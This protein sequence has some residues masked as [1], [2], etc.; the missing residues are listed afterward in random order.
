M[1]L[2]LASRARLALAMFSS[3]PNRLRLA[4][5]QTGLVNPSTLAT[6][7]NAL[8][9]HTAHDYMMQAIT[10]IP[11]PDM[12]L[13]RVGISR[14]QLA[15]LT[16]DDE[17][18]GAMET[19]RESACSTPWHLERPDTGGGNIEPDEDD[20]WIGKMI[21]RVWEPFAHA[22]WKS[23][24]FGYS[25]TEIIYSQEDDG[26][27]GLREA[28]EKPM[29]WFRPRPDGTCNYLGPT[30]S[31]QSGG[32]Q[33]IDLNL[34]FYV[35][36]NR[37]TYAN[38]YGEAFL[39]RLYWPWFFRHNAWRYWMQFLERFTEPFLA[40]K[41]DAPDV[42]V[43]AL[44]KL[45]YENVIAVGP[46]DE[47]T[48]V[49]TGFSG[50]FEKA[51][52]ALTKRVQKIILGQTLTTDIGSTSSGSRALGQVHDQVRQDRRRADIRHL[53]A[54]GQWLANALYALNFPEKEPAQFVMEDERGLQ[55]ERATRDKM[56]MDGGALKF[57]EQYLLRAYD[58]EEGDFEIPT[59]PVPGAVDPITGLPVPAGPQPGSG[60]GTKVGNPQDD[61]TD[62]APTSNNT[63][64]EGL[65]LQV[66]S[67][68]KRRTHPQFTE[69]QQQVE[70][71]IARLAQQVA[72]PIPQ[73]RINAAIRA[74]TSPQDLEHRLAIVLE[75]ADLLTFR[76]VLERALFA[77][78]VMGYAHAA[79]KS[80][81]T[82]PPAKVPPQQLHV[83][84]E[85]AQPSKPA[86]TKV[87]KTGPNEFIIEHEPPQ[88]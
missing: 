60:K 42:L 72:L 54:G 10:A 62:P 58:F 78:D 14:H 2:P 6:G 21:E 48:A 79:E 43:D 38:P 24:A 27:I 35:A 40:G 73:E 69:E 26:R 85:P 17:I 3:D 39:S 7:K 67:E 68:L 45:G 51:E 63:R 19:R 57:T 74:A 41:A 30:S 15:M 49:T 76:L 4:A 28:S 71:L 20:L 83:H 31:W 5:Q 18:D 36:R 46:K 82:T 88:E 59:P 22:V 33:P 44:L 64:T 23:A 86:R 65:L 37:A 11:D 50:E 29:Q 9:E 12:V 66:L 34:K 81:I 53:V 70:N 84:V 1:K 47:M 32:G 61:N 77:A 75:E 56:L 8:Y 87:T 16:Y 52:I 13:Q 25:V 55:E 80:G